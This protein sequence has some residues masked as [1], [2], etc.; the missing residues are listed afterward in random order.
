MSKK[1]KKK[2][3][4]KKK[5]KKKKTHKNKKKKN[6]KTRRRRRIKNWPT[7]SALVCCGLGQFSERIYRGRKTEEGGA[8]KY[9]RYSVSPLVLS[10]CIWY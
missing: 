8:S 1:K 3:R 5:K 7:P 9:F 4:K 10:T 6:K 2:N